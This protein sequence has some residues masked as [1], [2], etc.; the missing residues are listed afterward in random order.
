VFTRPY[1]PVRL[2]RFWPSHILGELLSKSWIDS[3]V[4][5]TVMVLVLIAAN[6]FIPGY[7]G[8]SNLTSVSRQ[9]AEFGIVALGMAVVVFCGGIDL[10]V[11]AV[12]ALANLAAIYLINVQEM[13]VYAM[14]PIVLL[15]GALLGAINGFFIGII[16]I[17]AFLVTLSTLV[18]FRAIIQLLLIRFGD[19]ITSAYVDYPAWDFMGTGTLLGVPINVL[20]VAVIALAFHLLHTRSRIGWHV[21]AVG[22]ARKS[23]HQA[24][25]SV[26]ATVFSAY[27]LCSTLAALG[28]IFFG[29]RQGSIGFDTGVGLEISV[30]AAIV[31]GG[32]AL[33]GGRGTVMRALAGA[34]IVQVLTNIM[35]RQGYAGGA[36]S[37]V[38]GI[39]LLIAIAF[40]I[41]WE[42]NRHKILQKTYVSP[43]F[44]E[45]KDAPNILEGSGSP[46]EVNDRLKDVEVLALGLVDGPEDVI[47]DRQGRLYTGMRHGWIY[48]LSGPGF[49]HREMLADIGGRPLGMAFDKDDNLIVCVSGMGLYG[50][51]QDG[52]IF[53]LTDRAPRS[54]LSVRDDSSIRLADDLDIAP[55]GKVYFSDASM[56][57]DVHSWIF[58]GLEGRPNGRILCYDP[59]TK[60]TS[61][62]LKNLIFPNG[63]CISHDGESLYFVETYGCRVSRLWI[64]GPRK[65]RLDIIIDN[66]PGHP[67]NLNRAS[68]G[69]YWL[70]LAGVR[71]PVWDLAMVM[72]GF[73]TRMV[74][75]IP[76]DEWLSPNVNQGCVIKMSPTGK[77]LA[78]MWDAE[79]INNPTI[80]SMREDRGWLYLGGLTSNRIT[81]IKLDD[82]DPNWTSPEAYWPKN[83][84]SA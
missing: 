11:G 1:A 69:N 66:L 4:P 79:A 32:V 42:K 33:G 37:A 55:D 5:V 38:L 57:Y 58:D 26:R 56:R 19:D 48:R 12:F 7:L 81:R 75:R 53:K 84:A 72:P 67:D 29:A 76:R 34:V 27:V 35:I 40:D 31:L 15:L 73:R 60:K 46:Y 25:I 13:S 3:V 6:T 28:G 62:A 14:V 43:A 16:K 82:A 8:G 59:A 41:K 83:G 36:T 2:Q 51:K 47:L 20:A 10:S 68:D 70:A 18:I 54:W 22:G 45:L 21:Q 74:K 78:C 77:I 65:G 17:R 71:S 49:M 61:V 80:T 64:A 39:V 30:I 52:T 24:G 9:F 50:V 63:M 23:A 44:N